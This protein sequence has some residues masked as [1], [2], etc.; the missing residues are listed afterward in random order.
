MNILNDL[1]AAIVAL[2]PLIVLAIALSPLRM[3]VLL[4]QLRGNR[5]KY[6]SA[7]NAAPQSKEQERR[8]TRIRKA[9]VRLR[10]LSLRLRPGEIMSARVSPSFFYVFYIACFFLISAYAFG[11][12]KSY[13]SSY[14]VLTEDNTLQ[15]VILAYPDLL[16]STCYNDQK[17]TFAPGYTI[18][19]P[20]GVTRIV[21]KEPSP[22]ARY[23]PRVADD[24]LTCRM[25]SFRAPRNRRS[26]AARD[27][28]L[29]AAHPRLS[30]AR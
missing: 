18:R 27:W 21:Y 12:S 26:K 10:Q 2:T 3:G 6:F 25:G 30:A 17:H 14:A 23:V 4:R 7:L 28:R 19:R 11:F 5:K 8:I 24:R 13:T 16:I 20:I 29:D 15:L 22:M 1:A 9:R